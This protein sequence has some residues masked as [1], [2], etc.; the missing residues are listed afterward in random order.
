M[1]KKSQLWDWAEIFMAKK[2]FPD[3]INI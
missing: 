2:I 3:R 1:K